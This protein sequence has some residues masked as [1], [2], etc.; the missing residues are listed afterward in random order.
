[1]NTRIL[2]SLMIIGLVGAGLGSTTMA[3][4]NDT[5]TSQGNE[6]VAGALDL[7]VGWEETYNGETVQTQ[8]L[9]NDPGA[10]FQLDDLK[11][12]DHGE[13]TIDLHL[14]DNPGWI[15]MNLDQTANWDNSCTEPEHKA[16]D[17]NCG[18]YGELDQEL[19][20]EIWSKDGDSSDRTVLFEGTAEELEDQK[21]AQGILLDGDSSTDEVEAFEGGQISQ[22]GIDWNLPIETGNHIQTDSLHYELEFYTEQ[23]RHN[24]NPENPWDS[25]ETKEPEPPVNETPENEFYQV[26]F[27]EGEPQEDL[28]EE[29][30]SEGQRMQRYAHGGPDNPVDNETESDQ[31]FSASGGEDCVDSNAFMTD[32]GADTMSVEFD[33]HDDSSC[34]D[35]E[36]S[37][38]SYE[39]PYAGWIADRADEQVIFDSETETFSPGSHCMTVDIPDVNDGESDNPGS[40]E[41][42]AEDPNGS[43]GDNGDENG[44]TVCEEPQNSSMEY[45]ADEIS[46]AMYYGYSFEEL[47]SE[48]RC[49]VEE[50]FNNQPFAEGLEL[51]D[52][53]T[54]DEISQDKFEMDYDEISSDSKGEVDQAYNNQFMDEETEPSD[55]LSFSDQTVTEEGTVEVND[56][57]TNQ[58]STV[59]VTYESEDGLVNAGA[60]GASNIE[61][62]DGMT[63]ELVG[64]ERSGEYT[65]H[66]I[67]TQNI[68]SA[69]SPGDTLSDST[70]SASLFAETA[71]IIGL[72]SDGSQE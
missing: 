18:T 61:D 26:D 63:I 48:T 36:L 67:P 17:G 11:P 35:I 72:E 53:M 15:W 65:A 44:E 23:R 57:T 7:T 55:A 71:N 8:E 19:E 3:M 13:A 54:R 22:V 21:A 6:F 38:V 16:S 27:V 24:D 29:T 40:C 59:F 12:G 9:M 50:L 33:V 62:F 4:F 56:V 32:L 34:E 46:A 41:D 70:A 68:S 45:T 49:E 42:E 1:M 10:I 14:H 64:P 60:H 69:Y 31:V 51:G 28:S 47:S 37:L 30:Y 20:F 2:I 5:E 39:K 58:A 25:N 66:I 43:E 52:L